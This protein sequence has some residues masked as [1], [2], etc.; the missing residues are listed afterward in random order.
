MNNNFI[1]KIYY[2]CRENYSMNLLSYSP[3]TTKSYK[4]V[5]N[6]NDKFI[7][8]KTKEKV[9]NKYL[10]LKNEGIDN[11]V[12]PLFNNDKSLLTRLSSNIYCDDC[13]YI[14]P[15]YED[16]NVLNEKKAND[17]LNELIILHSKTKFY[18]KLSVTKS[19]EKIEQMISFLDYQFSVLEAFV[20]TIES[21][22]YDEFSIPILKNYQ[23][24]LQSKKI[25]FEKNKKVVKA[26]KEEKS[27][28][29][30]FL[31][32]NPKLDHLINYEGNKYLISIDNGIIGIPS[33]D[34]AKFYIE[35]E[36]IY[37]DISVPINKYFVDLDDEF[38]K[39]YFIFLVLFIYI[40]SLTIDIKGYISTQSFIFVSNS[41]KKFT[42]SFSLENAM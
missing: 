26:I 35:N 42:K 34:I 37:F 36:D 40:K 31:H 27:V 24:I 39:D 2:D 8:K 4:V 33:L 41:I 14:L 9:K 13:Y 19:K 18:R 1:K 10:F 23:Y 17:L 22:P 25:I 30:C 5:T 20:R 16:K 6:N 12:Y 28:M 7:I 21:Q 29:F 32:N 3:I 38:Y 11:I 15:Y